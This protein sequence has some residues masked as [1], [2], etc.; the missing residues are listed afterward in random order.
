MTADFPG[1]PAWCDGAGDIWN[2]IGGRGACVSDV[3]PLRRRA[4]RRLFAYGTKRS[5]NIR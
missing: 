1:C 2:S 4:R 5:G 3:P